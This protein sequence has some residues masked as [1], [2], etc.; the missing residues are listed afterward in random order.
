[1]IGHHSV[2]IVHTP[3]NCA[4][5]ILS[6]G[7]W[8]LETMEKNNHFTDGLINCVYRK[9]HQTIAFASISNLTKLFSKEVILS[10][11]HSVSKI[12]SMLWL[13][14]KSLLMRLSLAKSWGWEASLKFASKIIPEMDLHNEEEIKECNLIESIRFEIGALDSGVNCFSCLW[15]FNKNHRQ[16][17]N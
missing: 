4:V 6:L 16:K 12:T 17:K 7:T 11:G 9:Y 14:S 15:K 2:C 3:R 1:M 5:K 8:F 10:V 13:L